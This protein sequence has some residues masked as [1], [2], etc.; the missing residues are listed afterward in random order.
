MGIFNP[1]CL[2]GFLDIRLGTWLLALTHA[3]A[4]SAGNCRLLR[5]RTAE[6]NFGSC[7]NADHLLNYIFSEET[8]ATPTGT[9]HGACWVWIMSSPK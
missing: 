8:K 5:A 9:E 7:R 2:V 1:S 6:S 3:K 4:L